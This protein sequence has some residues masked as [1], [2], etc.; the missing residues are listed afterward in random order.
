MHSPADE[1]RIAC[2]SDTHLASSDPDSLSLFPRWVEKLEPE[3]R[4][5]TYGLM[6]DETHRAFESCLQWSTEHK[7]DMIVHTG[8]VT[9]GYAVGAHEAGI[10]HPEMQKIAKGCKEKLEA[11][12]PVYFSLGNHDLGAPDAVT[13]P[14]AVAACQDAVGPLYWQHK[15]KDLLMLGVS[16]SIAQ[17]KGTSESILQYKR[18]QREFVQ[19]AL[20]THKDL[21]W[22]MFT[23]DWMSV[24]SMAE[25]IDPYMKDCK[26]ITYGHFHHPWSEN[27]SKAAQYIAAASPFASKAMRSMPRISRLCPSTAPLWGEGYKM[28][29]I[30][31]KDSAFDSRIINL[32]KSAESD[33]NPGSSF[34]RCTIARFRPPKK[35]LP[36]PA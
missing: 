12:A 3:D 13:F 17:Y 1:T 4:K 8:D 23:H 9:A 31:W 19:D 30:H 36:K 24:P 34:L 2:I 28:L 27:V 10:V 16:D 22:A 5:R 26:Q 20:R 6:A 21:P 25:D 14:E 15:R 11:I 32:P 33:M 18:D 29:D 35:G 7:P